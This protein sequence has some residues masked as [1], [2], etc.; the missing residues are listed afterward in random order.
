MEITFSR[1][2]SIVLVVVFLASVFLVNATTSRS[3]ATNT[4]V[5]DPWVDI[6][7]DGI[8]NIIDLSQI[9]LGWQAQGDPTR[10]V[11]ITNWPESLG[12]SGSRSTTYAKEQW[13]SGIPHTEVTIFNITGPGKLRYFMLLVYGEQI[14]N[15]FAGPFRVYIDGQ[16]TMRV[17]PSMAKL[18]ASSGQVSLPRLILSSYSTDNWDFEWGIE[19]AS[20][21]GQRLVITYENTSGVSGDGVNA[22]L[23]YEVQS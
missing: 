20:Y 4:N 11:N 5:Y 6:N 21:F 15:N 13:V 2:L 16:L 3:N 23:M 1:L 14:P 10:N 9:G 18:Y 7:G 12:G 19:A 22:F 8:I 17:T